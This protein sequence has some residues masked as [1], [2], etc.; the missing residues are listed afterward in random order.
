MRWKEL[1]RRVM[2]IEKGR[3]RDRDRE[4]MKKRSGPLLLGGSGRSLDVV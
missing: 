4:E 2:N 3:G 1:C